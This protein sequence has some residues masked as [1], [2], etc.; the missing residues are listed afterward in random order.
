[1]L[2]LGVRI[3]ACAAFYLGWRYT[4]QSP[5]VPYAAERIPGSVVNGIGG[6]TNCSTLTAGVLLA[7]Y[8]DGGWDG[9]SYGDLQVFADRLADG[10]GDSPIRAVERAG[11]GAR[12]AAPLP[13]WAL[14]QGWR[15]A[16][17]DPGDW[18]GHA[19][20]L[21]SR[22]PAGL[23]VLE[24]S[25]RSGKIGPRWRQTSWAGLVEEYA[26]GVHVAQLAED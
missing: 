24:A 20:I 26:A 8:P 6:V 1:M 21:H 22:G 4:Y 23:R 3:H 11:V 16:G 9:Q 2:P 25:S 10:V 14:C 15:V 13:G 12:V 5:R 19:V 17:P 7:V 18:R